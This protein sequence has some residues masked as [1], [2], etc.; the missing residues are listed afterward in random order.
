M[1]VCGRIFGCR[2]GPRIAIFFG[3]MAGTRR[4]KVVASQVWSLVVFSCAVFR[5][6]SSPGNVDRHMARLARDPL[7][8]CADCGIGGKIESTVRSAVRVAIERNVCDRVAP[9]GLRRCALRE[10]SASPV[11]QGVTAWL[12]RLDASYSPR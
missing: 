7:E 5:S 6:L 10:G 8:P 3:E 11:G 4:W 12:D 9:A 1:N 2:R